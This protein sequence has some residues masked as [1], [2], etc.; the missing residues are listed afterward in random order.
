MSKKKKIPQKGEYPN[1]GAEDGIARAERHANEAWLGMAFT[2][3]DGIAHR[4]PKF[5]SADIDL[6]MMDEHP[7]IKTHEK[8]AMAAVMRK[9]ASFQLAEPTRDFISDPRPNCHGQNKRV[10]RS[11][12]YGV[13]A[14]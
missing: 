2:V 6:E 11:L 13:K 14:A 8:R 10:W 9:M 5:T 12:V 7:E 4:Y 1:E 3:G